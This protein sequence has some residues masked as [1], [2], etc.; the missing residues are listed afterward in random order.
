ML[1]VLQRTVLMRQFFWAPKSKEHRVSVV[2]Y[3]TQD[4]GVAGSSLARGTASLSKTLYPLL[5]TGSTQEDATRHNWKIVV[6][7]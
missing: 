5:S 3:W 1:M 6:A 2:D 7:Y 4:Q